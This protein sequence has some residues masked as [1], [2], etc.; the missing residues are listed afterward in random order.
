MMSRLRSED[1]AIA[2]PTQAVETAVPC[3]ALSDERDPSLF[4][5]HDLRTAH[6]SDKSCCHLH[7]Q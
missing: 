1:P 7:A 5:P 3:F 4:H 2:E 6:I